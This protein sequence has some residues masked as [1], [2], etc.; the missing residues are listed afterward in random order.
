MIEME[1]LICHECLVHDPTFLKDD[2]HQRNNMRFEP[3][4]ACSMCK[5]LT[6]TYCLSLWYDKGYLAERCPHCRMEV[7]QNSAL[8]VIRF[9]KGDTAA[10]EWKEYKDSEAEWERHYRKMTPDYQYEPEYDSDPE[11]EHDEEMQAESEDEMGSDFA[12]EGESEPESDDDNER[13][14]IG[15]SE[16]QLE[17]KSDQ[18]DD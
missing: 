7:T 1:C 9:S 15:E 16:A 10:Q 2:V 5:K 17:P 14:S 13:H 6:H 11:S 12:E 8:E 18:D 4:E 3:S